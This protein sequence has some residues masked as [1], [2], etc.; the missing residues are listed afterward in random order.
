MAQ[1]VRALSALLEVLSSIPS[2][3][4]AH[5]HLERHGAL[6]WPASIHAECCIHNKLINLKKKKKKKW[7]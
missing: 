5:N 7:L 4:V 1:R 6:F 2:N 3:M